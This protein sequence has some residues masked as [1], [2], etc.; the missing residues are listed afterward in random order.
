MRVCAWK[1]TCSTTTCLL[2]CKR[3]SRTSTANWLRLRTA[4]GGDSDRVL[5]HNPTATKV[6]KEQVVR[7][8]SGDVAM[9]SG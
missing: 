3:Q 2:T 5:V 6:R 7:A 4:S 1:P 9:E 8:E